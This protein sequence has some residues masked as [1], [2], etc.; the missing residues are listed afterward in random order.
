MLK[1]WFSLYKNIFKSA[2]KYIL[3][4]YMYVTPLCFISIFVFRLSAHI[5]SVEINSHCSHGYLT[6]SCLLVFLQIPC[7]KCSVFTLVAW[8][9]STFMI[10]FNG[11]SDY[12]RNDSVITLI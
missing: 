3:T 6:P 7:G 11:T 8:I 5:A 2:E 10:V 12:L 1:L 4:L 9:S